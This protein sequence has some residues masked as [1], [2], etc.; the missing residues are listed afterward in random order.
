ML[1][2]RLV[3]DLASVASQ[4]RTRLRGLE[5]FEAIT[6]GPRLPDGSRTLPL[7]SDDNV[8]PLK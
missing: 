2:K 1:D 4:L 5:N 7:L 8:S 6:M 3:P